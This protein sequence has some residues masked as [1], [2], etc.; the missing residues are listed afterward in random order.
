MGPRAEAPGRKEN[1]LRDK[2]VKE[3]KRVA[4]NRNSL[5]TGNSLRGKREKEEKSLFPLFPFCLPQALS[6]FPFYSFFSWLRVAQYS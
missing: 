2:G 4:D 6:F 3:V 5:I 1:K